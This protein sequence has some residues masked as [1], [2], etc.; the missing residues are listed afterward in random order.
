[1]AQADA[2]ALEARRL[3]KEALIEHVYALRR[4][5]IIIAAT[6]GLA[7]VVMF[8]Q[9]STQL[10]GFLLRPLVSRGI[11]VI[12][13]RVSESLVMQMKTCLVAALICSMPMI[14]Y[15][16]W[17]FAAPAL[18]PG[19]KRGFWLIF[20][21]MLLLFAVGIVFAY[22]FVFPLAIDLFYEA[23]HGVAEAMWSVNDYFN[24]VLG[25]LLPFGLMFELP[26]VVWLLARNGKVTAKGMNKSRKYFILGAAVVAAI[27][28]PPDVVSQ[29]MLLI[30]LLLLYELSA[31]IVRIVK[32]KG[33]TQPAEGST[34]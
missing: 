20:L 17:D 29:T 3:K 15:Q 5:L 22:A 27:L 32:P 2:E 19:E 26:V 9:M 31:L 10:A 1:M 21:S 33:E 8:Y 16:I 30:P 12:A 13:T 18:Y 34:R 28:T 4:M 11:D 25:F 14:I 6:I 7:F 23:G 24:F